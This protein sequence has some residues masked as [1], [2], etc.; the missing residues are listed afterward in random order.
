MTVEIAAGG[1]IEDG[2]DGTPCVF[3]P[4]IHQAEREIAERLR[5]LASGRP[6]WSVEDAEARLARV[7]RELA[8][9]LAPGQRAALAAALASKLLVITGG[10]GHRQ[11]H[12]GRGDP[13]R[14]GRGRDRR[15]AGGADRARRAPPR[16]EHGAGRQDPAPPAR[17]RTGPRLPPGRR[18]PADLRS[19]DRRRDV[20]GRSAADAGDARRAAAAKRR[21][22]WSATSTSCRRSVRVRCWPT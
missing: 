7:E 6:P 2:I 8:L 15:P 13:A 1:L 11:D 12:A 21:C 16:R 22:C 4:A 19:P 17:G 9:R 14:S 5:A 20:D 3:L 10:P 18:A